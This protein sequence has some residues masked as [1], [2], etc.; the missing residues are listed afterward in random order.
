VT[1][2]GDKDWTRDLESIRRQNVKLLRERE[3]Y[4]DTVRD[5]RTKERNYQERLEELWSI[6]T[7][8]RLWVSIVQNVQE[9]DGNWET[10]PKEVRALVDRFIRLESILAQLPDAP[11]EPV[12]RR[13]WRSLT[14]RTK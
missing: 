10:L 12:W 11:P 6:C 14:G 4:R 5:L 9:E 7:D 3:A 13:A 2:K 8:I 1:S